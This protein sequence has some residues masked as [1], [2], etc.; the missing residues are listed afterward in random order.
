V[1]TFA[2]LN[3]KEIAGMVLVDSAHEDSTRNFKGKRVRTRELSEGRTIPP[4]QISISVAD[5]TLSAEKDSG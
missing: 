2:S 1:R 3:P 5:K 4:I